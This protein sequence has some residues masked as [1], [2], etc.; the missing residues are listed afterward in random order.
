MEE[1]HYIL[2]LHIYDLLNIFKGFVYIYLFTIIIIILCVR[3]FTDLSQMNGY[4]L[5][6]MDEYEDFVSELKAVK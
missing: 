4:E 3:L 1:T 2:N 6:L 5:W